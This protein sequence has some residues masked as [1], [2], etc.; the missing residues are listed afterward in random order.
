[1]LS[2]RIGK[3]PD[4]TGYDFRS[5]CLR[6][7]SMY[8]VIAGSIVYSYENSDQRQNPPVLRPAP[9]P[10]GDYWGISRRWS[11][12]TAAYF[13][14]R[15]CTESYMNYSVDKSSL[16]YVNCGLISFSNMRDCSRVSSEA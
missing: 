8:S 10:K 2:A 15:C 13:H 7:Q 9:F 6:N 11:R 14:A 16:R 5:G 4:K 12:P 1:M 3:E